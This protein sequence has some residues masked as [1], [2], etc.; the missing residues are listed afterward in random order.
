M[1]TCVPLTKIFELLTSF[2][3]STTITLSN[4]PNRPESLLAATGTHNHHP[5]RPWTLILAIALMIDTI[6]HTQTSMK[7]TQISME[8]TQ[9][10]GNICPF[11]PIQHIQANQDILPT[12]QHN[13]RHQSKARKREREPLFEM[14]GHRHARK[15]A[16]ESHTYLN[17][18]NDLNSFYR[19]Y[20]TI[21]QGMMCVHLCTN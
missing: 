2:T 17:E 5:H 12:T 11:G 20:Y 6:K 7:Y 13:Q 18:M 15:V 8:Y 4:I 10:S 21:T 16:C 1:E 9:I 19:R 14:G 3:M